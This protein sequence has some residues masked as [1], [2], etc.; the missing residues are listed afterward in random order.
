[1]TSSQTLPTLIHKRTGSGQLL[2]NMDPQALNKYI[3]MCIIMKNAS[4]QSIV[5]GNYSI[6]IVPC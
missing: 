2:M 4:K 6:F 5:P 1:M 3:I